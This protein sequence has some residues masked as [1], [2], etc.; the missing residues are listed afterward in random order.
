[1]TNPTIKE[2]KC[3][4]TCRDFDKDGGKVC[5]SPA[6][7]CHSSP[8]PKEECFCICHG[9]KLPK[10]SKCL[11][12]CIAPKE[13]PEGQFVTKTD[14]EATAYCYLRY[15]IKLEDWQAR[16]IAG[17][18]GIC[19]EREIKAAREE[20]QK[21]A[22]KDSFE[23]LAH[24]YFEPGDNTYWDAIELAKDFIS[25]AYEK[26]LA[27][28]Q[29]KGEAFRKGYMAG[30]EEVIGEVKEKFKDIR[31]CTD[32]LCTDASHS[33]DECYYRECKEFECPCH[34]VIER[35]LNILSDL[36]PGIK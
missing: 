27:V 15:D 20:H 33:Q 24:A 11:C 10:G 34:K 14:V 31:H 36:T 12:G 4:E 28:T 13:N 30:R 32:C 23:E 6:C 2:G 7:L 35:C 3:C 29:K 18:L 9:Q 25:R 16:L 26:G 17:K 21:L 19:A 8:A 22:P 1:M 5:F